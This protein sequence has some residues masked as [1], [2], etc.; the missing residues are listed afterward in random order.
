M[1]VCECYLECELFECIR[2]TPGRV[3]ELTALLHDQLMLR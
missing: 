1:T 2:P 3:L